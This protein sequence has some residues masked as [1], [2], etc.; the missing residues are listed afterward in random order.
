MIEVRKEGIVLAKSEL[1][2]ENE[3]ILNPA[4]IREGDS[5]HIFYRAVQLWN[6]SSPLGLFFGLTGNRPQSAP[7]C[8][9]LR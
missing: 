3:G 8:S 2:F 4:V 1:E 7:A 6:Q 9:F 5:V